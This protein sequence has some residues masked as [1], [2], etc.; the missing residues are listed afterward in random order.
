M[1]GIILSLS[2]IFVQLEPTE[3]THQI[4]L[5]IALGCYNASFYYFFIIQRLYNSD[6]HMYGD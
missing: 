4:H 5:R 2:I 6:Y 1:L 3:E